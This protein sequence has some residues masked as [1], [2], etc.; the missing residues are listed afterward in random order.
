M[1]APSFSLILLLPAVYF[2]MGKMTGIKNISEAQSRI[3]Q[4]SKP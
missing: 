3:F 1:G 4:K 2:F